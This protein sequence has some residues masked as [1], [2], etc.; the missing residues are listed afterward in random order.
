MV[1]EVEETLREGG[2]VKVAVVAVGEISHSKFKEYSN[3]IK[4]FSVLQLRH[5]SKTSSLLSHS[6][7]SSGTSSV[8]S[9]PPSSPFLQRSWA[10][11]RLEF[12]F[13]DTDTSSLNDWEELKSHRK[14][15]GVVGIVHCQ[16]YAGDLSVS[17]R[18][19]REIL[20]QHPS[21]LHAVCFAFEP[22]H[23][24]PDLDVSSFSSS[25]NITADSNSSR[26]VNFIMIPNADKKKLLFYLNTWLIDFA[27]RML[28]GFERVVV[29]SEQQ[30]QQAYIA[31]PLDSCRSSEEITK[32]KKKKQ[33]RL[34]K[35][36]ADLALLSASPLDARSL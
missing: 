15:F 14:I 11:G 29:A 31:T 18:E 4:C 26:N 32:L 25:S 5:F 10:E 22:L 33:G 34:L 36:H 2:K 7:S 23:D 9:S 19:F 21:A 8:T 1:V 28:S 13:V 6:N 3:M 16:R 35:Q 24:Q 30:Q 12:D 17:M 27:E 20:H